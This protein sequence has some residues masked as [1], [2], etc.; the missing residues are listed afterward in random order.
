MLPG[1]PQLREDHWEHDAE[2]GPIR[3][4]AA[5]RGVVIEARVWDDPDLAPDTYD[6][7]V[8]GTTWDYMD[9][10]EAFLSRLGTFAEHRP[11]L[12]PLDTVRWNLHKTYLQDLAGRNTPVVPTLWR[13]RADAATIAAAFDELDVEEIV[14]KPVVGA[15]AWRQVRLHRGDALPPA[16]E[17][18]PAQTM[19]QPFL[20]AASAEGEYSF[21]FFDREFS[22]CALKVPQEG[23]YRVQSMYGGREQIYRP[24]PHELDLA[25]RVVNAVDGDLL[26]ARVDM[27]R[28]LRGELALMEL[29]LVEPYLYPEQGP[30]MGEAFVSALQHL[31][32]PALRS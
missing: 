11:L 14:V 25:R 21:L 3:A 9:Q 4:A 8:I 27:M 26:Y 24:S 20:P 30:H 15:S 17:L 13:D 6:A 12:N 19:I 18:P 7:F 16:D 10:P 5:D 31:L 29:E 22:H 1:H 32:P 28:D 23:E 2:F